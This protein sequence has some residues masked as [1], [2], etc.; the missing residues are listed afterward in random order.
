MRESA[1]DCEKQVA[2]RE[3]EQQALSLRRRGTGYVAIAKELNCSLAHAHKLVQRAMARITDPDAE[4]V[5]K[6]E[7]QRL[8]EMQSGLWPA[9]TNGA[10][11]SVD[12]VLGIMQRRAALMGLDKQQ[13]GSLAAARV[14]VDSEGPVTFTVEMGVASGNG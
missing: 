3:K 9:A 12:R 5:R 10:Y 4:E 1:A 11:L 2:A 6:L 8:D 7:L 14:S 13:I